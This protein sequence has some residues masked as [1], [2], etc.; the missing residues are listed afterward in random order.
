MSWNC[1]ISYYCELTEIF[2]FMLYKSYIS[3]FLLTVHLWQLEKVDEW[4]KCEIN[5]RFNLR[6]L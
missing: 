4:F 5:E 2:Q 6:M 3:L 1:P